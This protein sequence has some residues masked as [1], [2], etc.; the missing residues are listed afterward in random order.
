[1]YSS[2]LLVLFDNGADVVIGIKADHDGVVR[3]NGDGNDGEHDGT[4]DAR[5]RHSAALLECHRVVDGQTALDCERQD[6]TGGVVGEQVAEV[7][8]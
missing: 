8:L 5:S 7:L 6:Q 3:R 1:M 4:D 2:N